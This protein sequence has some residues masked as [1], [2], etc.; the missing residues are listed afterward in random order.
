MIYKR[1]ISFLLGV[2]LI[3][4]PL[5]V[6]AV[7]VGTVAPDFTLKDLD[8]HEYSLS[9][10]KGR[11]VVLKLATTWCPSCK[12]LSKN[13][14]ELGPYLKAVDAVFVDV[15]VQDSPEMLRKSLAGK[16]F[17]VETHALLDDDQVYGAYNIYMIP[18]LL[19]ID[20]QMKVSFDNNGQMVSRD[21]I[22]QRIDELA[23]GGARGVSKTD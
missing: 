14:E 12:E 1:L 8:G 3:L 22:K 19:I 6:S 4:S 13:I 2:G 9:D 15:Y 11:V 23:N 20:Q 10:F 17:K 18:R 7:E 21:L 16:D 5:L